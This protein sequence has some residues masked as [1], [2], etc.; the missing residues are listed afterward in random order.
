RAEGLWNLC[1]PGL[2][3]N[4]PGTRL[5]NLDYAPLAEAMGRLPWSAEVFN[6]NAPDSGNMDLLQ[7]NA[8]PA[9]REQWLAPLL[10][11]RIRSAFAMSEP[12]VASSDPTNL[13]TSVRRQGG[14]LVVNGRKWFITGAAHPQC[15]LLVVV[16]RNDDAADG[17][18]SHAAH[19]MVLVP[20]PCE[21]LEVV[22][23]IPI[24]QHASLEG[25]CEVLM[26]K[27]RVPRSNLL[28]E[29]GAGF[30]MAQARLG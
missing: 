22:R 24:M 13:Q 25:H 28:G 19:N 6:C 7:R 18:S 10:E 26:R 3:G 23:N 21:G 30:A 14:E 20:M 1:L 17:A 15:R 2:A 27:V 12:D 4:E 9:Q 29:W 5:N 16:C 8:T 11:G